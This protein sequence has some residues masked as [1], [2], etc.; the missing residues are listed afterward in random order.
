MGWPKC[1][2]FSVLGE[3]S[4]P[5]AGFDISARDLGR[6]EVEVGLMRRDF[7]F[8][9]QMPWDAAIVHSAHM[10][11]Q[12]KRLWFRIA[13]MLGMPILGKLLAFLT[14][15]GQVMVYHHLGDPINQ[16][17]SAA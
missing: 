12:H 5:N 10:A 8:P 7:N 3:S 4:F 17:I 15:Y 6:C 1:T 11:K 14:Q 2:V 9:L 16:L 13:N